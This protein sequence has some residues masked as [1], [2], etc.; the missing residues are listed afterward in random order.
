MTTVKS[1]LFSL[2]SLSVLMVYGQTE[3][4]N[5]TWKNHPYAQI[6]YPDGKGGENVQKDSG[7]H[8]QASGF[9]DRRAKKWTIGLKGGIT[10]FH[11][12]ADKSKLGWDAGLFLKY[13]ISQTFA[14]RGE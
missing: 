10:Q 2:F 1:L 11:G 7:Q 6:K 14:L 12:D 9:L 13:S 4:T 3:N 5:K 8:M